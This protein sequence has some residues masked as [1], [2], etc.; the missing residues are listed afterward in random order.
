M[1]VIDRF[2]VAMTTPLPMD[3]TSD[4]YS[5]E[6]FIGLSHRS[7][8]RQ[9]YAIGV[10]LTESTAETLCWLVTR[11]LSLSSPRFCVILPYGLQH[12]VT[13]SSRAPA[14]AVTSRRPTR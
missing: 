10:R 12:P 5:R 8:S 7:K 4:S 11:H 13:F 6:C 1:F 3:A 14:F 9:D 2:P